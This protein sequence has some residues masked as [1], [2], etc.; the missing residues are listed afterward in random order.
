MILEI[1]ANSVERA[2]GSMV[3]MK[4]IRRYAHFYYAP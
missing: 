3:T 1:N 4:A 2:A